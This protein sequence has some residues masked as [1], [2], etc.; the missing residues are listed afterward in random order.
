MTFLAQIV[1][2]HPR[3]I[4]ALWLIV[5]VVS[6][7]LASKLGERVLNSGYTPNGSESARVLSLEQRYFGGSSAPQLQ[8]VLSGS[9]GARPAVARDYRAL[10]PLIGAAEGVSE[11]GRPLRSPDGD[12]ALV[13]VRLEGDD[14]HAQ[15]YV[16]A[17]REALAEARLSPGSEAELVGEAAIYDRMGEQSKQSL[18]RSAL[19]SFP[20]MLAILLIAFLSLVAASLPLLLS[21]ICVGTTFGLLYLLSYVVELS[22]FVEDAVLVLGLGLSIDFSLFMLTRVREALAEGSGDLGEAITTTLQ[23]TGR[24]ITVSGL[25]IVVALGG[26][27]LTG[28]GIFGSLATGSIGATLL[29][30]ACAVTLVPALLYLLGDRIERMPIR[31]AANAAKNGRAWIALSEFVVRHRVSTLLASAGFMVVLSLPLAGL[32]ITFPTVGALPDSDPTP[33]AYEVVRES[34]GEGA[35]VPAVVVARATP[36]ELRAVAGSQPGVRSLGPVERGEGGMVRVAATLASAPDGSEAEAT[37]RELRRRVAAAFGS[38]QAGVGGSTALGIDV[39]DRI[40][41][42]SPWVVLVV[43]LVSFILLTL[44]F[45]APLLALKASLTTLLSVSAALG[46]MVFIFEGT[47]ITYFVPL[48]L[49]TSVFG[50]STDYEVFLLSRMREFH[51]AGASN[52]EAIK[53]ALV[54]SGRSITLAGIAMSVVFFAFAIS[55]LVPFQELGLA[56]GLAILLDVTVMRCLLVPATVALLGEWNWWRPRNPFAAGAPAAQA[57]QGEEL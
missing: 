43:L 31:V 42:R 46:A 48:F 40:D 52:D 8:V 18:Q 25:T 28:I 55:P 44:V 19:I 35:G 23:T 27:Y 24:A 57:K 51:R 50:L 14:A 30:V 22:V 5:L 15:T 17:I 47:E 2:R 13:P 21:A 34:F 32:D 37:V 11:V 36:G 7:A 41:E 56:M 49:F 9:D 54:R 1:L 3:K 26:C 39:V 53:L 10:A 20:V 4:V 6:G 38:Q 16:P 12:V 29:A 33:Q 45:R